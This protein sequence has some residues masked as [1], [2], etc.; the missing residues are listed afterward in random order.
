MSID[1]RPAFVPGQF[2]LEWKPEM[3][4]Q[5][6]PLGLAGAA[7]ELLAMLRR[8]HGA[9]KIE[10]LWPVGASVLNLARGP[11]PGLLFAQL[12]KRLPAHLQAV[13]NELMKA[14]PPAATS[15]D[16]VLASEARLRLKVTLPP[17][18]DVA[19]ALKKVAAAAG[20]EMA[21]AVP[22]LWTP[23]V[24]RPRS[25]DEMEVSFPPLP[26]DQ[27]GA[28]QVRP[29]GFWPGKFIERPPEW[30]ELELANIAVLDSGCDEKHPGLAGAVDAPDRA[31]RTDAYGHGTFVSHII[32]GRAHVANE[33]IGLDPKK[34]SDTPAGVLP[35]ARVWVA[36]VF[37][38]VKLG[39]TREYYLDLGRYSLEL[40]RLA[41]RRSARLKQID[42]LNLSL[43]STQQ[44]KVIQKD[45]AAVR[46]AGIVVVAAAG[47][48]PP[49]ESLPVMYPAADPEVI[50]VGA[51]GYPSGAVWARSNEMLPEDSMRETV[52]DVCAPG[53]WVLSGLPMADNHLGL[54]FSGWLSG[55]SMAAPYV[56]AAVAVLCAQGI[57]DR[58]AI[59]AA[60][61]GAGTWV[62]ESSYVRLRCPQAAKGAGKKG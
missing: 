20:V 16:S 61:Q 29:A 38:S 5:G 2:V 31:S 30:D 37:N 60:L 44:S 1:S 50:S 40:R 52:W 22:Y 49:G 3:I 56:T 7:L 54:R 41:G 27:G 9:V 48:S 15:A 4:G 32:A 39:D 21:E 53:E 33:K 12:V 43:G 55:T 45:L 23:G 51:L 59:L 19:A 17:G 6:N 11:L 18:E 57:K 24:D 28:Y 36:N 13:A 46:S 8:E 34:V 62:E 26:P 25:R 47:N 10:P 58:T 14:A 42:V 35:K